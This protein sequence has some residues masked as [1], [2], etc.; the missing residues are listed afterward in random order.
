MNK[1]DLLIDLNLSEVV[2]NKDGQELSLVFLSMNDG[3]EVARIKCQGLLVVNYQSDAS[4]LPLY[5]GK[6]THEKCDV[7]N[8]TMLLKRFGYGFTDQDGTLLLPNSENI[9]FVIVEGAEFAIMV[10]CLNVD[11]CRSK[12]I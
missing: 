7:A 5:V 4:P 6:V 12:E 2:I 1:K 3:H 10:A 11:I 8:S 9:N